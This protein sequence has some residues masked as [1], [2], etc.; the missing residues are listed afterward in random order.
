MWD[1][2]SVKKWSRQTSDCLSW[3]SY[4]TWQGVPHSIGQVPSHLSDHSGPSPNDTPESWDNRQPRWVPYHEGLPRH[5]LWSFYFLQWRTPLWPW[6]RTP[7]FPGRG[8]PRPPGGG[9]SGVPGSLSGGPPDPPGPP[10]GGSSCPSGDSGSQGPPRQSFMWQS[11]LALDQSIVD[12]DR[13]VMQLLTAQQAASVKL[14][15]QN[16]AE[17]GC[18]NSSYGCSQIL[19]WV[20]STKEFCSHICKHTDMWWNW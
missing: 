17:S 14:Q 10:G 9:P 13:S 12:M 2:S 7:S 20:N 16:T 6:I 1:P 5:I 11:G 4:L 3:F 8:P 19:G 18:A 15:L